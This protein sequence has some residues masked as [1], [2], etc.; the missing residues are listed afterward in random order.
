[1][2][3]NN[4]N[5]YESMLHCD[6]TT[7]NCRGCAFRGIPDCRNAM[8]H[9]AGAMIQLQEVV[10]ENAGAQAGAQI[11]TISMLENEAK[12]QEAAFVKLN[13]LLSNVLLGLKDDRYCP[14]C[15]GNIPSEDAD[16]EARRQLQCKQCKAEESKWELNVQYG[17]PAP[18]P[19]P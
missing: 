5:L 13:D 15:L 19:D 14:A 17:K 6:G 18:L 2:M 12:Q 7:K 3:S 1:M 10:I 4:K 11:R 16:E 9:H 8:A